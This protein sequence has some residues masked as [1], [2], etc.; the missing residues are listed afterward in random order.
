MA[1]SALSAIDAAVAEVLNA[2]LVTWLD[3]LKDDARE[4]LLAARAKFHSGGY[5][6][7]KRNTLARVLIAHA[8]ERGWKIPQAK[9]VSEWLAKHD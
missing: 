9:G 8:A 2:Q 5:G 7:L 4:T 1:K 6:T 3:R